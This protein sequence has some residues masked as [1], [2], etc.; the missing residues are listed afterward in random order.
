MLIKEYEI[1]DEGVG[2]TSLQGYITTTYDTLLE[3]FGKP[4]YMDADP[5]AKV[6]C[7]WVLNVKY[8]E[9]EGME[10]FDYDYETVTIYNWKDGHVPLNE[11]SWHVG[12]KSYMASEIA[13]LIVD[14]GIKAEYNANS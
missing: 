7:E 13:Q 11:C 6:N 3:L 10:D 2:G 8:F 1:E 12:G 5:Y 9:E 14:G 4:T